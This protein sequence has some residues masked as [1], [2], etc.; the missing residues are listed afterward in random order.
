M[1]R[2]NPIKQPNSEEWFFLN[3]AERI[4][5]VTAY[6]KHIRAN[7]PNVKIHATIHVI[8]ENQLAEGIPAVVEALPRLM[9]EGLDRHDAIHAIGSVLA[10]HMFN[11]LRGK[12][13][14]AKQV[15]FSKPK[16]F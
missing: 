11:L 1:I 12:R 7:L 5:L 3:E 2:Y 8:I 10:N 15:T 13:P 16:G 9:N 14:P 6:H 4:D